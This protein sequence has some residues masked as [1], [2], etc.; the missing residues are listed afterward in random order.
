MSDMPA[1]PARP[2][3]LFTI[4]F[5]FAVF[6]AFLLVIRYLYHPVTAPAFVG[7]TENLSKELQWKSDRDSRRKELQTVRDTEA[8]KVNGYA[9]ADKNAGVVQLP[10]E[11]A[12]E[13]TAKDLA[14][15]QQVRQIRD[16][17]DTGRAKF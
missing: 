16:L 14:A 4:V 11:R 1:T 15:K 2:V 7:P 8:K 3:S 5:L 6:A 12:M 10:V 13:L 17:P 9:W